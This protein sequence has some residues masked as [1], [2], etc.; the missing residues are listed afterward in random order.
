MDLSYL[1]GVFV[2]CATVYAVQRTIRWC[3]RGNDDIDDDIE[4][5]IPVTIDTTD[6][7][8]MPTIAQRVIK[9]CSHDNEEETTDVDKM[10]FSKIIAAA[11][12]D[13]QSQPQFTTDSDLE[14]MANFGVTLS[15]ILGMLVDKSNLL[16]TE[17]KS[18]IK[19]NLGCIPKL[20][21]EILD[22]E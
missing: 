15:N 17:N 11:R 21:E 13:I 4:D 8:K 5:D 16:T 14:T 7:T 6:V 1:T 10:D 18:V 22:S 12:S 2:A 3:C 20:I 9:W 19:E